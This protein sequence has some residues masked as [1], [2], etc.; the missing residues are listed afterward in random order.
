MVDIEAEMHVNMLTFLKEQTSNPFYF[1]HKGAVNECVSVYANLTFDFT[2][3]KKYL[4]PGNGR[5]KLC[6]SLKYEELRL[7]WTF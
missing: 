3:S 7:F 4:G 5:G 2:L 1:N 6:C